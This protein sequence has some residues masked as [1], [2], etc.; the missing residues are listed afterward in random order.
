MNAYKFVKEHGL[1]KAK[2]VVDGVPEGATHFN[3]LDDDE[4]DTYVVIKSEWSEKNKHAYWHIDALTG[5]GRWE[6]MANIFAGYNLLTEII[7]LLELKQAIADF[8]L[9]G[10]LGDIERA[11]RV[12]RISDTHFMG[13]KIDP[14]PELEQAIQRIEQGL[15]E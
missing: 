10:K 12:F 1:E 9:V 13:C 7:D 15:K 6:F 14:C 3:N 4:Y 11:K 8:E 5:K 2:A